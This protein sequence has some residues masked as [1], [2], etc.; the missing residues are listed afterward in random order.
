[1]LVKVLENRTTL[2]GVVVEQEDT[3]WV[4]LKAAVP[5]LIRAVQQLTARV[6]ELEGAHA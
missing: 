2:P 3:H 4:N 5:Y 1:M 6:A